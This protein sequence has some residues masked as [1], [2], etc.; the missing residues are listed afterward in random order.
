MIPQRI[1]VV[2][3]KISVHANQIAYS[4]LRHVGRRGRPRVT[5]IVPDTLVVPPE[6]PVSMLEV[7][8]GVH[9]REEALAAVQS[10]LLPPTVAMVRGKGLK[11]ATTAIRSTRMVV[12]TIVRTS[13]AMAFSMERRN[14]TTGTILINGRM[15][16]MAAQKSARSAQCRE[17]C[18]CGRMC[19]P[20][21]PTKSTNAR[22]AMWMIPRMMWN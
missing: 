10:L 21:V 6:N 17:T 22:M 14:V 2:R 4:L 5:N 1:Q 18:A 3:I 7:F 15:N 12:P 11:N 9:R 8:V 19:L 13:V 20:V 16:Q